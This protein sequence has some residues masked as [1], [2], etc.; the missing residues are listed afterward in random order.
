MNI[1][2]LLGAGASYNALP[3]VEQI[4]KALEEFANEFDPNK[5]GGRPKPIDFVEPE[6]T[7]V[8]RYLYSLSQSNVGSQ[9]VQ[10][11]NLLKKFHA[12]IVWLKKEAENHTSIDTF[13][14]KLY[15]QED[16][17]NLKKLKVILSCFFLYIQNTEKGFDKRYDSFL[18]SI[19]DNLEDLPNEIRILSWNYDSQ[20]ETAFKRFSNYTTQVVKQKLNRKSKGINDENQVNS[21]QFSLFKVNGTTSL[22]RKEDN[23]IKEFDIVEEF[24]IDERTL[25]SEFMRLYE[26]FFIRDYKSSMS[27]AWE[28]FQKETGFFKNLSDSVSETEILIVIGYSFPFFNREIDKFILDSMP[29]LK[30]IY[31]QD[32]NHAIDI[33][34]KVKGL[35]PRKSFSI[36]TANRN[37][38]MESH[39]TINYIPKTFADQFFIPIEF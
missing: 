18:A 19:L 35:T 36:N 30:R 10:N 9:Y 7:I 27:F 2:Y 13:A 39:N 16:W 6:G 21:S 34:E 37:R 8:M 20:L 32:P 24:N 11:F 14:K 12:D 33:I 5:Y 15:L 28:E 31:V 29:N 3:I 23:V 38:K 1:T 4:P 26:G 25:I 22:N 17:T